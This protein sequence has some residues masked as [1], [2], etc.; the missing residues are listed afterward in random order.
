MDGEHD[1]IIELW[2]DG[3]FVNPEEVIVW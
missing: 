2:D 3:K 1:L